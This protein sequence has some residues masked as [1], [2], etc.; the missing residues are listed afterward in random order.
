MTCRRPGREAGRDGAGG[1]ASGWVPPAHLCA[2]TCRSRPVAPAGVSGVSLPSCSPVACAPLPAA[3]RAGTR[4]P[5]FPA[6][7][8][9]PS[10]APRARC[11]GRSDRLGDP[12]TVR[13]SHSPAPA[14]EPGARR[15]VALVLS[16]T[17]ISTDG[18]QG[19]KESPLPV[20]G[21]DDV[22]VSAAI[23][24]TRGAPGRKRPS[25]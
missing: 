16:R 20:L 17:P 12:G 10:P 4:R 13:L 1:L 25:G 9:P 8:A 14:A 19:S 18:N 2:D 3:A 23:I 6:P 21:G 7:L 15:Q 24:M 5:P 22:S 11:R